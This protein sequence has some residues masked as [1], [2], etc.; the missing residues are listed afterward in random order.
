MNKRV[1]CCTLL[2]GTVLLLS[3]CAGMSYRGKVRC[4]SEKKCEIEGEDSGTF[5]KASSLATSLLESVR[6]ADAASF[7]IDTAGSTVFIPW[8]GTVMLSLSRS[9][10]G[11]VRASRT[12]AWKRTGTVIRLSDPNAVNA[13]AAAAGA[14][15]D[16]LKYSLTRF[17]SDYGKGAQ[18]ISA[19]SVYEGEVVATSMS[20]FE[21]CAPLGMTTPQPC[22]Q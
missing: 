20:A 22:R 17:Q 16:T 4:D 7:Q 18:K 6:I 3:A 8:N 10:D 11:A 5:P 15:A 12:F 14:D 9:S 13:W 1:L 2:V 19:A 21:S